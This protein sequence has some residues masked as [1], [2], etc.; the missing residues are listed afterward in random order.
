MRHPARQRVAFAAVSRRVSLWPA[1]VPTRRL[2]R[3]P[4]LPGARMADPIRYVASTTIPLYTAKTG[5]K[6]RMELLWGDRVRLLTQ[7]GSRVRVMARGLEGYVD[8]A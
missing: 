6:K 1:P 4:H 5:G 3:I 7:T 2:M 8:R